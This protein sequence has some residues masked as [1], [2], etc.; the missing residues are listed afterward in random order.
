ML[1]A[2]KV[3]RPSRPR[4][5]HSLCLAAFKRII[6]CYWGFLQTPSSLRVTPLSQKSCE[7]PQSC[8]RGRKR[9]IQP[10]S[11]GEPTQ[12]RSYCI[13]S[14]GTTLRFPDP[15]V[16]GKTSPQ[17]QNTLHHGE[18][19]GK[20]ICLPQHLPGKAALGKPGFG[21]N[22]PS[23]SRWEKRGVQP[24]RRAVVTAAPLSPAP[25]LT[26]TLTCP[27]AQDTHIHLSSC[28][29]HSHSPVPQPSTLT[30]TCPT[31]WDTHTHLSSSPGH[32]H[33]PV[34]QPRTL[35][36]TC[37]RAQDTHT[38]LSYLGHSHSPV[39]SSDPQP[40]LP[41]TVPGLPELQKPRGAVF[42]LP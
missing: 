10:R 7:S 29:G 28:L 37:P 14:T 35:T 30:L 42:P 34:P 5:A 4:A 40:S 33:S 1:V 12:V 18:K 31:A 20:N 26:G 17:Q 6:S 22:L 23:G 13:H 38:H 21:L 25:V 3:R 2:L 41:R 24:D 15:H 36:L 9:K 32:S 11:A 27:T 19:A 39:L 8:R 16:L